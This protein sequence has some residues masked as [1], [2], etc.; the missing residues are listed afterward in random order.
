MRSLSYILLLLIITTASIYASDIG[1]RT[2]IPELSGSGSERTVHMKASLS[3]INIALLKGTTVPVPVEWIRLTGPIDKPV[4]ENDV[5]Y[6]QYDLDI[7]G[8]GSMDDSYTIYYRNNRFYSQ[9]LTLKDIDYPYSYSGMKL[10]YFGNKDAYR[11]SQSESGNTQFFIYGPE[12]GEITLGF[13]K[14]GAPP[15]VIDAPNP[16]ILLELITTTEAPGADDTPAITSTKSYF[17]YTNQQLLED[18]AGD[19]ARIEWTLLSP[20]KTDSNKLTARQAVTLKQNTIIRTRLL[21]SLDGKKQ[22]R[23]SSSSTLFQQNR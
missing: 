3:G 2:Y 23:S 4:H 12:K 15:T 16:A 22:I 19:W 13:G 5:F 14:D 6:S 9:G 11:Y 20:E 18:Q 10:N 7:N 1:S 21:F 8:N 17:T